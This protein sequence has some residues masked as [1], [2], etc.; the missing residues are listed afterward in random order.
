MINLPGNTRICEIKSRGDLTT[1]GY[2]CQL[3][4]YVRSERLKSG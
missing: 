4:S 3:F 1:E 2:T